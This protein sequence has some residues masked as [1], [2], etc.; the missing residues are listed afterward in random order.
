ML[1][2]PLGNV[3]GI[4]KLKGKV[5]HPHLLLNSSQSRFLSIIQ[6]LVCTEEVISE[7]PIRKLT[8]LDGFP[9]AEGPEEMGL[10]KGEKVLRQSLLALW[11]LTSLLH[12]TDCFHTQ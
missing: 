2:A 8:C 4:V 3:F 11:I 10:W 1:S 9:V 5:C 12:G 6:S 7:T